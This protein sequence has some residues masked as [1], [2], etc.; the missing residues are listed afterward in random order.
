LIFIDIQRRLA[1]VECFKKPEGGF[2][3]IKLSE[4][5]NDKR[6]LKFD[7]LNGKSFYSSGIVYSFIYELFKFL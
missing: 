4:S 5:I 3:I 6:Y 1:G 7:I 2:L